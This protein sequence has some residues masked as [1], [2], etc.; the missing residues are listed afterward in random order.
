MKNTLIGFSYTPQPGDTATY[1]PSMVYVN[2]AFVAAVKQ[3]NEHHTAIYLPGSPYPL[4]VNQSAET[5]AHAL[6]KQ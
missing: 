1:A 6:A 2:P 3:F 4:L 5:V